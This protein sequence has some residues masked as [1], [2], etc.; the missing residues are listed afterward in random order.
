MEVEADTVVVKEEEKQ[1]TVSGSDGDDDGDGS[2]PN[3]KSGENVAARA[4]DYESEGGDHE[5]G[6]NGEDEEIANSRVLRRSR[7][8]RN[9]MWVNLS[10]DMLSF[11]S[12]RDGIGS[13]GMASRGKRNRGRGRGSAGRGIGKKKRAE[14]VCENGSEK[15]V[16]SKGA[17]KRMKTIGAYPIADDEGD[18]L[19]AKKKSTE[20]GKPSLKKDENLDEIVKFKC[21]E[22]KKV[23]HWF[24]FLEIIF[25]SL[26]QINEDQMLEKEVE[27]KIQEIRDGNLQG[28]DVME[29]KEFK[30]RGFD[31]LHGITET[32]SKPKRSRVFYSYDGQDHEKT[33]PKLEWKATEN[34]S[35]YC[36]GPECD[37]AMLKLRY[38]FKKSV[39]DLVKQAEEIIMNFCSKSEIKA[40]NMPTCSCIF[41]GNLEPLN[42]EVLNAA[43]RDNGNDNN[44]YSPDAMIIQQEDLRHFQW[45][46]SK[47]QPIIVRN[48]LEKNGTGLRWDPMVMWR[49]VRQIKNTNYDL[50]LDVTAIDC[51]DWS[52]VEI[53]AHQFFKGYLEG[54]EDSESWP[55]ILKLKD[56]PTS[57]E[58]E[59]QLP[60]HWTEFICALPF[61]EYTHPHEGVLNLAVCLPKNSLKPDMGPKTYIAYG[62]A[63]ELGR[64]DSVT[65]LHTDMSD[66]VNILTHTAEVELKN[67][68]K[69]CDLMQKHF[70][71][72]QVEL[73]SHG[74][75]DNKK[76]ETHLGEQPSIEGGALW[77]IFRRE[78]RDKLQ[79]YLKKHYKEFR[80]IHCLPLEKVVHPIHDQTMYL[81]EDHKRKLKDEFGI[82][83]WTFVQKL[84]DAVFIPAGCPHQVRN[85]KSCIKVALDFVSP[86][87]VS[88]CI[89]LTEEFRVLPHNHRGKEDKI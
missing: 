60:R 64:G 86:E 69:V 3:T 53:N 51:L 25:P 41:P 88:E 80:H 22:A 40:L 31:Y 43:T 24:Y 45:H 9:P 16:A 63:Q 44:L 81:T 37:S 55:Q 46:W 82:E 52:E 57:T 34:G 74:D 5:K 84:G 39:L 14:A 21:S 83:P 61:K 30:D 78:D 35:I 48:V 62:F 32:P 8:E 73:H 50:N 68:E 87:N 23:Q 18:S 4:K 33:K 27:A 1:K 2:C 85:L 19:R 89:R 59:K 28:S 36:P 26:K 71:Q 79:E 65:K 77:D 47:A 15:Q 13:G 70:A 12:T 7:R 72:D 11:T 49:A 20:D 67:Q 58:F 10:S 56:W 42:H 29:M 76:D 75:T 38:M 66:A 17:R 54:R 6:V